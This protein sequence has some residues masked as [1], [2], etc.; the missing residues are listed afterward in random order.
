M[1]WVVFSSCGIKLEYCCF[2]KIIL[3]C[4]CDS[5]VNLTP[6]G[7]IEE[8]VSMR[9]CPDQV[10]LWACRGERDCLDYITCHGK[11]YPLWAAPSF[12]QGLLD[13]KRGG[14]EVSIGRGALTH[15]FSAVYCGCEWLCSWNFLLPDNQIPNKDKETY[16]S[17]WMINLSLDF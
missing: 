8:Y 1:G 5:F 13:C 2:Q 17:L 12:R 10:G 16:Y 3:F 14:S 7:I 15:S 9:G 4:S 6:P 11:G